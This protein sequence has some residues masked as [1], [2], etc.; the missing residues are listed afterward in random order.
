MFNKYF[1]RGS[2]D[3]LPSYKTIKVSFTLLTHCPFPLSVS[4]PLNLFDP[5]Q[6]TQPAHTVLGKLLHSGS[7]LALLQVEILNSA[8]TQDTLPRETRADA[9]HERTARGTEVVDH[10]VAR[11]NGTML[12]EGLQIVAAAQVL[13]VGVGDGEVG[14]EHRRGDFAAV[15]AVADEGIDKAWALGRLLRF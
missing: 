4:A 7:Q 14:C 2:I 8:D 1:C 3:Q 15:R 5:F 10:G 6:P 11:A 12:A 13:Q 9:V